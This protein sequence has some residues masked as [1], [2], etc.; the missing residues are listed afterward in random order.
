LR[1]PASARCDEL[2]PCGKAPKSIAEANALGLIA[3][4]NRAGGLLAAFG[5]VAVGGV[6]KAMPSAT[7]LGAGGALEMVFTRQPR[8]RES[9]RTHPVENVTIRPEIHPVENVTIRPETHATRPRAAAFTLQSVP[10][11]PEKHCGPSLRG[12]LKTRQSFPKLLTVPL[13]PLP[14]IPE[15]HCGLGR[16]ASVKMLRSFPKSRRFAAPRHTQQAATPAKR[17]QAAA[18]QGIR[19]RRMLR[20]ARGEAI[21]MIPE[22]GPRFDA[23]V[24]KT[25]ATGNFADFPRKTA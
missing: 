11:I 19:Q 8:F 6:S 23:S 13:N 20:A 14:E 7:D 18:V 25:T 3:R 17:Q 24:P 12:A 21:L 22:N 5:P 2:A 4:Q 1:E 10:M 9:K 15:M 16:R